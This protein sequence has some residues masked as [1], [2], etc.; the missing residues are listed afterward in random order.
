MS[1]KPWIVWDN[2]SYINASNIIE[3]EAN[4]TELVL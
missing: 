3:V 4:S 1:K 2:I